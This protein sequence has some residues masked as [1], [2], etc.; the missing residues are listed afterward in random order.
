[1]LP[2]RYVA[3]L[4]FLSGPLKRRGTL[5]LCKFEQNLVYI[6]WFQSF[7]YAN[8]DCKNRNARGE[9][10][11]EDGTL[12]WRLEKWRGVGWGWAE[13]RR[14]ISAAQHSPA[15]AAC[16]MLPLC[17]YWLH[18]EV[19]SPKV[20]GAFVFH[21]CVPFPL[22]SLGLYLII[23]TW[24]P[25]GASHHFFWTYILLSILKFR[26]NCINHITLF[27]FCY[28]PSSNKLQWS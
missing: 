14:W 16:S 22:L 10:G 18:G 8:D 13:R 25:P 6:R 9:R 26:Y 23:I 17:Y 15:A 28:F 3:V 20:N 1:M 27:I 5:F 2:C 21:F 19:K 11:S 24:P 4:A 12:A 7:G